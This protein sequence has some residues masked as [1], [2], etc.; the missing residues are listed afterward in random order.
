M[1]T[2]VSQSA[3]KKDNC[4]ENIDPT[5]PAIMATIIATTETTMERDELIRSPYF[6]F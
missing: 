2:T 3:S 5:V 6:L 4:S 1:V